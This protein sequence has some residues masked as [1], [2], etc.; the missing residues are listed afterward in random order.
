[1]IYVGSGRNSCL[2]CRGHLLVGH[3]VYWWHSLLLPQQRTVLTFGSKA[4]FYAG[5]TWLK[6]QHLQKLHSVMSGPASPTYMYAGSPTP[7]EST[8]LG[9]KLLLAEGDDHL[10]QG[11]LRRTSSA[12]FS[13]RPLLISDATARPCGCKCS[14]PLSLV[15]YCGPWLCSPLLPHLRALRVQHVTLTGWMLRCAPHFS[16]RDSACIPCARHGVKLWLRCYSKLWDQIL[17]EQ[18]WK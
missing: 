17:L 12:F 4:D 15:Q 10:L 18:Q 1:M 6:G 5:W 16:W 14:R 9:H 11:F 8:Y 13:N 2:H 3:L 7:A